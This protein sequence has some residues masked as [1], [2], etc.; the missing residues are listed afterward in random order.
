MSLGWWCVVKDIVAVVSLMKS[1]ETL[2]SKKVNSARPTVEI[3]KLQK[4][5]PT[6]MDYRIFLSDADISGTQY[7]SRIF[8][9]VSFFFAEFEQF[10]SRK[11]SPFFVP[12]HQTDG[13]ALVVHKG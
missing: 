8:L 3:N 7:K 9:T 1:G 11:T 12:I 13:L 10:Q 4:S 2:Y 5:S 6:K